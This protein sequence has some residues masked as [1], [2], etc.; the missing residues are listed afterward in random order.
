MTQSIA[1]LTLTE[2]SE[3]FR[4]GKLSP[5]EVA[6]ASLARAAAR[7]DLNVFV[8]AADPDKV[9]SLAHASEQRWR[10]K[11]PYGPLDGVPITIKDAIY[12]EDWPTLMGSK[13]V[14]A[15]NCLRENAPAV[16]RMLEQGAIILGKTTS[17]EFG[18]KAVTD[19]P[20]TGITR[21]PWNAALT[22][23]GSSGGSAAAL[24][25]GIGHAAIGTDAGGSV[26]IPGAFCGLV[27]LKAT[28]GRIPAYPPSGLWTLGHIG[29]MCLTVRD[30][31]LMLSVMAQPDVRDW[32]GAFPD[33]SL[34]EWDLL[35]RPLRG[36]RIA[37]SPTFGYGRVQP[38]V[39]DSVEAAIKIFVDLGAD[40]DHVEAPFPDPTPAFRT[41]FAAGLAH[42]A[43]TMSREQKALLEQGYAAV[44]AKGETISRTAFMEA[45][46]ASMTLARHMRLFHQKYQILLSPTVAVAP[47][48]AGTLSPPGYDSDDWLDWSPFTYPFNMSGQPALTVPCG[49]TPEGL[50]VGLQLVGTHFSEK[51]LLS[52]AHAYERVSQ[53]AGFAAL[54]WTGHTAL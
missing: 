5:V 49:L 39:A 34:A 40:I 20:L 51:L 14:D 4:E 26:R 17:P 8:V 28:R 27:G 37:F 54:Q 35:D 19:S 2:T 43:R 1:A 42:A 16:A 6:E 36:V 53:F 44:I 29:P 15:S 45:S 18:W 10:S 38:D 52:A 25:A 48:A 24:A 50:P 31:S 13:A 32:N 30:T 33:P 21:N 3:A 9:L 7:A 23:G 11:A 41:L 22:P 47:F 12:T 46:E